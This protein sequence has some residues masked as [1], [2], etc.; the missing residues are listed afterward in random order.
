MPWLAFTIA[1]RPD[2]SEPDSQRWV[3]S[4]L[5]GHPGRG[6]R[7]ASMNSATVPVELPLPSRQGGSAPCH[8]C[9]PLADCCNSFMR[10]GFC[11]TWA[12]ATSLS[13][14]KPAQLMLNG[15]DRC[16]GYFWPVPRQAEQFTQLPKSLWPPVPLQRGQV[17]RRRRMSL[18]MVV[19]FAG[20]VSHGASSR[21]VA[22]SA[23]WLTRASPHHHPVRRRARG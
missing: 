17:A 16:A 3:R 6:R 10:H 2:S 7:S 18:I 14:I 20:G 19:P 12:Q 11:V 23:E 13:R 4:A 21:G 1:T 5:S 8:R 22:E 15:L 9:Q